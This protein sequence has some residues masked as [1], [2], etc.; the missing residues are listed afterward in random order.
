MG[1]GEVNAVEEVEESSGGNLSIEE[2][3]T[4]PIEEGAAVMARRTKVPAGANVTITLLLEIQQHRK[5]E[6][7]KSGAR[8]RK[9]RTLP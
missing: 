1:K 4:W 5:G 6:G 8:Q 9:R 3:G 7:R 2:D